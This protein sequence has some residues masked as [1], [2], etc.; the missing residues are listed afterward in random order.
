MRPC[1]ARAVGARSVLW[2]PVGFWATAA[3]R[4]FVCLQ[5]CAVLFV[6]SDA[7]FCLFAA[8]RCFVCSDALFCF[9]AMRCIVC[10]DALLCLLAAPHGCDAKCGPALWPTGLQDCPA[11]VRAL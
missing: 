5:R 6:C 1:A 9:A 2:L 7:L 4:C 10:S 8:M 11:A 3:M